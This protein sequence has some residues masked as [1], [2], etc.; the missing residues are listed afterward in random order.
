[1][2]PDR[3]RS[4]HIVAMDYIRGALRCT[5]RWCGVGY[6]ERTSCRWPISSMWLCFRSAAI[7]ILHTHYLHTGPMIPPWQ[8]PVFLIK[9]GLYMYISITSFFKN[10]FLEA[11]VP[12]RRDAN[13]GRQSCIRIAIKWN[14][15]LHDS[16]PTRPILQWKRNG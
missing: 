8:Q 11:N 6:L 12:L 3:N 1:M 9:I 4:I 15:L 7:P 5:G 14:K 16:P 2:V 13:R 10:A